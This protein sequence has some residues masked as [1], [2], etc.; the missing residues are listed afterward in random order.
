MWSVERDLSNLIT[1]VLIHKKFDLFPV[2]ED[3]L[4]RRYKNYDELLK[5]T[6]SKFTKALLILKDFII[7]YNY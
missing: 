6:V 5:D 2:L 3:E 1:N 7:F 4:N